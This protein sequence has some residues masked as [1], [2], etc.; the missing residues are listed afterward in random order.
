MIAQRL[1]LDIIL[2]V[3][4]GER[5]LNEG[6]GVGHGPKIS[7]LRWMGWGCR[8]PAMSVLVESGE[9]TLWQKQTARQTANTDDAHKTVHIL[10]SDRYIIF[11]SFTDESVF[12]FLVT[13]SLVRF[14]AYRTTEI[15]K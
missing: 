8:G 5:R 3:S 15:L 12:L 2:C 13:L 9:L 4:V 7:S 11:S 6:G 14:A 10:R 1:Y